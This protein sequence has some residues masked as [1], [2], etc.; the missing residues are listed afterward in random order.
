MIIKV[1]VDSLPQ[2]GL[3]LY[4]RNQI[5]TH[6]CTEK[7]PAQKTCKFLRTRFAPTTRIDQWKTHFSARIQKVGDT[8]THKINK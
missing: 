6:R 3:D 4:L 5:N 8:K 2:I 1:D 7:A